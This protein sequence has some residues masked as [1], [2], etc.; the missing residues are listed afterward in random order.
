MG[1]PPDAQVLFIVLGLAP[2]LEA[3]TG[4]G[5]SLIATVPLLMSLFSRPVG[6]RLALTG[7]AIMP[8]G[9]L[10]LATAI[11]ALLT[12]V[13][14]ATLGSHSALL[15]AP[16]FFC[17]SGLALWQARVSGAWPWCWLGLLGT[18]VLAGMFAVFV[19]GHRTSRVCPRCAHRKRLRLHALFSPS[20]MTVIVACRG[21]FVH[22]FRRAQQQYRRPRNAKRRLRGRRRRHVPQI[23]I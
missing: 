21:P 9:T 18:P 16:V 1:G 3:M 12:G 10:E 2:L 4:F 22:I 15:S 8:W 17:L 6:M 13:P 19:V 5:V 20:E 14:A 23:G 11:G 7:M